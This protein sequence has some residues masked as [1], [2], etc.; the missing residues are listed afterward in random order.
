[1]SMVYMII[2][3]KNTIQGCSKNRDRWQISFYMHAP[4]PYPIENTSIWRPAHIH[5]LV[6]GE[7]QQ[8][9]ITQVYLEGDPH[10]EKDMGSMSPDA[11]K[12]ILKIIHNSKN[13]EAVQFDI[14]MFKPGN[15]VFKK[16]TGVYKMNDQSV[17]EFYRKD[18]LLIMKWNGQIWEGLSYKGN[19]NFSGGAGNSAMLKFQ[20]Q[21]KG[22]VKSTVHLKSIIKGEV[23]L[24]GI[25]T[26][27]Y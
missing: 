26:F 20:L 4:I 22:E 24:E 14:V 19:N 27:N 10:L 2:H 13:E 11:V 18:D 25:R 3:Q 8:D 15:S 23:A 21:A 7:G 17:M 1:M 16:L 6:S 12:R 5:L 9:F